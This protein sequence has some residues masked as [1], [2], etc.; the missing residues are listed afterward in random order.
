VSWNAQ[1]ARLAQMKS[2]V[3]ACLALGFVFSVPAPPVGSGTVDT[4]PI[5][6]QVTPGASQ[7]SDP[8]EP[9][10]ANMLPF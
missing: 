1:K 9:E 4:N 10:A 7:G 8:I 3:R 2:A 6:T 5:V